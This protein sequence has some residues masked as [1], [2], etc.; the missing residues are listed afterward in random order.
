M[1][2]PGRRR[3]LVHQ[4]FEDVLDLITVTPDAVSVV[5][6]LDEVI[7]HDDGELFG[8]AEP[9]LM[10]ITFKIDGTTARIDTNF[11]LAGLTAREPAQRHHEAGRRT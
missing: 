6:D 3:R 9:Y 4:A 2:T 7:V 5:V 10:A 8:G 1:S 11:T